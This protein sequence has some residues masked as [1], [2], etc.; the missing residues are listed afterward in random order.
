MNVIRHFRS[1][2]WF[3]EGL[4]WPDG[5]PLCSQA[6]TASHPGTGL[7]KLVSYDT[8]AFIVSLV[9]FIFILSYSA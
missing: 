8:F 4:A 5:V 7:D 9:D 6:A 1:V 3:W 2:P